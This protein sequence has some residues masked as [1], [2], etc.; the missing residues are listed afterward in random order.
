MADVDATDA[1]AAA[2][3]AADDAPAAVQSR[4]ELE[5]NLAEYQSQLEQVS[6][7]LSERKAGY[8]K[9]EKSGKQKREERHRFCS[10]DENSSSTSSENSSST[11]SSE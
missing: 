2:A 11:S 8:N 1:V 10:D 7:A 3:A 4:A 6:V 9:G 5:A